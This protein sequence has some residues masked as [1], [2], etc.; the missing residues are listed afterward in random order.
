MGNKDRIR[1]HDV[2]IFPPWITAPFKNP[3]IV[4]PLLGYPPKKNYMSPKMGA[5]Q[6]NISFSTFF[7]EY[8]SFQGCNVSNHPHLNV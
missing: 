8:V 4:K 7:R 3:I 1:E 5:F 2:D 6:K